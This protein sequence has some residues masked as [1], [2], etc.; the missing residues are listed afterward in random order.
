L[1]GGE[2]I[3]SALASEQNVFVNSGGLELVAS[4]GGLASA[5]VSGGTVEYASRAIPDA[6]INFVSSGGGTL[7]LDE[8]SD[9]GLVKVSGFTSGAF[10]DFQ[11]IAFS[12]SVLSWNQINTSSGTLSV[13]NGGTSASITLLGQ[14]VAGVG[15]SFT[16][17][18]DSNGG[19]RVGDPPVVAQTDLLA[20]P[21]PT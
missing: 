7:Q 12:G 5:S 21:H 3:V 6:E 20:N 2:E 17:A 18:I 8:A 14:Y 1:N 10:I 19:T 15:G 13:S 9:Y 11:A 4:Q 16:S